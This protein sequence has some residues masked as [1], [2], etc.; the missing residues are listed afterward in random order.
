MLRE[1]Y[2]ATSNTLTLYVRCIGVAVTSGVASKILCV[3]N[4]RRH[5]IKRWMKGGRIEMESYRNKWLD[6]W[7][8]VP[9]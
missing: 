2:K 1:I 8:R 6:Q 5:A 7:F 3:H 4:D 9:V